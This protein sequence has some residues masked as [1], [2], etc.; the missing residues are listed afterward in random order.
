LS[1]WQSDA[2]CR[3]CTGEGFSKRELYTDDEDVIYSYQRCIGLNG[4]NIVATKPDLLDRSILF[5]V[6][7]IP[8][9]QRKTEGELWELF[10]RVKNEILCGIFTILSQAMVLKPQI[11]LNEHPRMADFAIWG[12]A[13]AKALG[14]YDGAFTDAYNANIQS[15]NREALEASPVGELILKFMEDK[16]EWK[17]KASDLLTTLEVWLK[18]IKLIPNQKVSRR[19]Q[20]Y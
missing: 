18:R 12:C 20:T 16:Q 19:L 1:D 5:R 6:E 10:D 17:G 14:Y 9:E 4:I 7:R 2:L 15:Q 13:I 3:A 11:K 8:K